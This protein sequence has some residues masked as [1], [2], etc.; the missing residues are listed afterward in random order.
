MDKKKYFLLSF[1]RTETICF[2]FPNSPS[3]PVEFQSD[4]QLGG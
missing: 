3:W 1:L 2:I 4:A